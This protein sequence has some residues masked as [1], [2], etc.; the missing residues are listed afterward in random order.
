MA[1]TIPQQPGSYNLAYGVNAVTLSGLT[2]ED[3]YVLQILDG[4]TILADIR[5]TPNLDG[6]AEF[7]IQNILQTYVKPSVG[8]IETTEGFTD[9]EEETFEYNIAYG[10]ERDGEIYGNSPGAPLNIEIG[11]TVIGGRKDYYDLTFNEAPFIATAEEDESGCTVISEQ[12]KVLTDWTEY[13]L[14]QDITD[15]VPDWAQPTDKVYIQKIRRSD[16][17]TLSMFNTILE[18][19]IPPN[20]NVNKIEALRYSSYDENGTLIDDWSEVNPL[21]ASYPS[22]IV[23]AGVGPSQLDVPINPAAKYYYVGFPLWTPDTCPTDNDFQTDGSAMGFYRFDIVDDKCNDYE[24]I[25]FSWMNSYGFRDYFFFEKKNEKSIGISRNNYL[26]EA[27]NYNSGTFAVDRTSRGYTTYSQQLTETY[28]ANTRFLQDYEASFLENLF[29]SPD[30]KVR[31]GDSDEW[32]PV[33]LLTAQYTEKNYRKD[34]LF[35]YEI[36]FKKAHNIKSQRG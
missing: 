27:N 9:S 22:T 31:F 7:D 36:R 29:I 30:V 11:L 26:A 5:Q 4:S 28:T 33:T 24:P 34:K 2:V 12:G 15:E 14:I 8:T 16:N 21:S 3:K 20:P 35:Q 10:V 32:F 23:T 17:F 18:G 6:K 13:K 1:I 19:N 25:Q